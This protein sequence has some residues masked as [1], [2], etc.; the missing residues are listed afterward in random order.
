MRSDLEAQAIGRLISAISK[1]PNAFVNKSHSEDDVSRDI[2]KRKE[3]REQFNQEDQKKGG[4]GR[5]YGWQEIHERVLQ[6]REMGNMGFWYPK[7]ITIII[8]THRAPKG[9]I[10]GYSSGNEEIQ[11]RERTKAKFSARGCPGPSKP[12]RGDRNEWVKQD[13]TIYPPT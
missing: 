9:R 4:Q 13:R 8:K 6:N 3:V 1:K 12:Q 11:E 5:F 7:E 10:D 2:G